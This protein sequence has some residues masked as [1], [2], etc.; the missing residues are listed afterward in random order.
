MTHHVQ[1]N[2]SVVA[3]AYMWFRPLTN[4]T[5]DDHGN[6]LDAK[7]DVANES[8]NY[9]LERRPNDVWLLHIDVG[10]RVRPIAEIKVRTTFQTEFG[11]SIE[12][13]LKMEAMH[14]VL[15]IAIGKCLSGFNERCE[16]NGISYRH[17]KIDMNIPEALAYVRS[18]Y[19]SEH[20]HLEGKWQ[21]TKL[22]SFTPGRKTFFLCRIPFMVMDEAFFDSPD[23]DHRH[24]SSV[25]FRHIPEPFYYTTKL[26]CATIDKENV[27]LDGLHSVY[28]LI[29]LDCALQLLVGE[30]C[31]RFD[32]LVANGLT[33]ETRKEFLTFGT[34][35]FDHCRTNL[36][37]KGFRITNFEKRPDWNAV[38][39]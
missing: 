20:R 21:S 17:Q 28:Y 26:R 33:P 3:A 5:L 11:G 23:F 14:D 36:W 31:D 29:A 13:I 27:E 18:N 4:E 34:E 39:R 7:G 9:D 38:I 12:P 32:R 24:N 8:L 30:H 37:E 2:I 25:L 22:I 1:L 35:Y 19:E 16:A 6:P 10:L 15:S